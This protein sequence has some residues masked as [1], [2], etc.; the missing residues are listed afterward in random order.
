MEDIEHRT[1]KVRCPCT[2]GFLE[3]MNRTLLDECLRVQG[4]TTWYTCVDELQREI[5]TFLRHYNLD[6]SH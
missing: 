5:D 4:G 1:T 2:N 3:R 6:R